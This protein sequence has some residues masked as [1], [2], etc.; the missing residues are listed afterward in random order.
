MSGDDLKA[1]QKLG[2]LLDE[3]GF[4]LVDLGGLVEFGRLQEFGAPLSGLHMGLIK[5]MNS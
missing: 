1:K 4:A 2:R 3:I 5:Q